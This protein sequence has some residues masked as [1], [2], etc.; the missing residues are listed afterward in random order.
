MQIKIDGKRIRVKKEETILEVAKRNKIPIPTLCYHP[1]LKPEGRCRVCLVEIKGKLVT[2]CDTKVEKKMEI[3][4]NTKRVLEAR[5]LNV[6]LLLSHISYLRRDLELADLAKELGIRKIRFKKY[7]DNSK[8]RSPL[9]RDNHRCVLC[10]RC[11]QVCQ[12][13]QKINNIDFINRGIFTEVNTPYNTPLKYS[14]CTF[15]GQCALYCPENAL[16]ERA[17]NEKLVKYVENMGMVKDNKVFIV[18]TAPAIRASLGEMFEMEPG[19]LVTGKM[20]TALRKIGFDKVFDTDF[21]ADLTIMEEANEFVER[22]KHN[23]N[24]PLITSCCPSWI[25]FAEDNYHFLLKNISTCKSPQQMFG[26]VAKA[27]YAKKIGVKP[28]KLIVVSVM[29]C[30][31]KKFEGEKPEM[32]SVGCPDV[33]IVLTTR[34]L[35]RIIEKKKIKFAKLKNQEFDR[36]LGTSSG[37]GAIFGVTGGVT[38]SAFRVAYEILTGK[39]L[40]KVEF[41]QVRGFEGIREANLKI[42]KRNLKIAIVHGLGNIR[43]IIESGRWKKYHFIEMMACPGGCIGGGGQPRPTTKEIR[44][45]RIE[46]LY[47]QDKKMEIRVASRNPAIKEIYKEFL[48]KPLSKK[49]EKFLHTKYKKRKPVYF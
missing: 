29:P 17:F 20:V 6:E 47:K 43:K 18:Q 19:T 46:A 42:G 3:F 24:L 16:R 28:D 9:E 32:R 2:S 35:G 37:G 27:Y 30:I 1:D 31:S 11:V 49:A 4:T 34:E 8:G 45:R 12:N 38:E 39:K 23:K 14:P 26:A 48:G 22:L 13:I 10:G 41:R 7:V 36:A 40:R 44:K 33:D 25:K 21:G 5:R 15:C